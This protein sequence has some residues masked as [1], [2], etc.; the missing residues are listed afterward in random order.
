M[1]CRVRRS[2]QPLGI[3]D[4]VAKHFLRRAIPNEQGDMVLEFLG[5]EFRLFEAS[6]LTRQWPNL[7]YPQ[8]FKCFLVTADAVHWVDGGH[9][10]ADYLYEN[11]H[12]QQEA[13][14]DHQILRLGYKNQAPTRE[15]EHHH[16]YGVFVA[17]F[18]SKQ[19]RIGE[20]IGGG[21]ADRSGGRDLTIGELLAWADWKHHFELS[22]CS[23]AIPIVEAMAA[24]PDRL[25]D[26]LVDAACKC[27]GLPDGA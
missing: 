6:A 24:E 3:C 22:G 21:F 2:A 16:V 7:A 23:W 14:L 5:P 20:S 19:F 4:T 26:T 27:N 25:L 17:P 12:P 13:E 8:H 11:S 1:H 10:D 18:S 15:D 9:V